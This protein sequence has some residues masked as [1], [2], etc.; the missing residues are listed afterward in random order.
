MKK[1]FRCCS[2]KAFVS[3]RGDNC[4]ELPIDANTFSV[5]VK[6]YFHFSSFTTSSRIHRSLFAKIVASLLANAGGLLT[7]KPHGGWRT[8]H[9]FGGEINT[10]VECKKTAVLVGEIAIN[11]VTASVSKTFYQNF[12]LLGGELAVPKPMTADPTK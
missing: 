3:Y 11:K 4:I 7:V 6:K 1:Y 8:N 10:S 12:S 5:M 2:S 9:V